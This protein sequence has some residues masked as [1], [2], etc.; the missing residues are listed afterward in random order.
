LAGDELLVDAFAGVGTFAVLLAP[1]V[2]RVIAIE[3]SVAAVRDATVNG[4]GI[5]GLELVK[6]KTEDVLMTLFEAPDALIL[7][8]PR[9]GCHPDVLKA[10]V[11]R[12]PRRIAYV[13]CEPETL[14][15]DL[16]VL[17][18]GGLAVEAVEPIDMFPQTYHVECVAT[19]SGPA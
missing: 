12:P 10:I 16:D 17:V 19:L 11:D 9:S 14:A 15:R 4:E 13:S 5:D 8:P 3:E 18:R 1:N 7:D 2:R 6:A